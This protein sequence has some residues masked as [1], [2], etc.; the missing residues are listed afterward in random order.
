MKPRHILDTAAPDPARSRRLSARVTAGGLM[1]ALLALLLP[2]AATAQEDLSRLT[3]PWQLLEY[4]A[5]PADDTLVAV[6][7]IGFTERRDFTPEETA[8]YAEDAATVRMIL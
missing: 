8:K 6:V 7:G 1:L 2:A 4:R 5:D 3:W